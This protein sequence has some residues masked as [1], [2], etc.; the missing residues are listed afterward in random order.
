MGHATVNMGTVEVTV[1][2]LTENQQRE[3]VHRVLNSRRFATSPTLRAFLS[4]ITDH[5][6]AG[7]FEAI[8][9]QQIGHH[10]LGRKPGYDPA[11]D[12]IV[13]V[14]A[15]QVRQKLEEYFRD[16]GHHEPVVISIPKGHYIPV[17]QVRTPGPEHLQGAATASHSE[18]DETAVLLS[19]FRSRWPGLKF[20]PWLVAITAVLVAGTAVW[21]G[22]SARI[23][24]ASESAD[25]ALARR[26]WA[27]VLP[28]RDQQLTV[29]TADAGFA[30][31]QD[32]THQELNLGAYLSRKYLDENSRN[33]EM[34][35][36][37]AR[38][39][40]SPA[41]LTVSLRLAEV[42]KA[43]GGHIKVQF[44]RSVD[45]H[46]VKNGTVVLLGSRRSNPWVELF[47]PSMNF[48]LASQPG[49]GGPSLLNKSP[50]PGEPKHFSMPSRLEVHGAEEK[51]I[52]SYALAALVPNPSGHGMAMI[53]EGLS[54]EGTE[55]AGELITNLDRF[56]ALL[57]RIG[58]QKNGPVRPF[59]MLLKLTAVAG[60]YGQSELCAYRYD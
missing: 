39:Y 41:D 5:A 27:S 28:T 18:R 24:L 45:I 47:E 23:R 59:E 22:G 21:F 9:E 33:P 29:I 53:V 12:N 7:R 36:I 51:S 32:V 43:L 49:I 52:D 20:V 35:E 30:L 1:N 15:R 14:R 55:A 11:E 44:A 6:I 34:R 46:D 38:R 25:A 50:K 57:R 4:Y 58:V 8:K 37:A 19:N 42:A 2:R 54:M 16:E 31:W 10:V 3:L 48:V 60:G 13:R 40:T 17:F 56:G 26:A